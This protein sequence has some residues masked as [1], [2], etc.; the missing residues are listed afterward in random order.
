M[1]ELFNFKTEHDITNSPKEDYPKVWDK[2]AI[3]PPNNLS[4]IKKQ[5]KALKK[6]LHMITAAILN[7]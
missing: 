3:I 7:E 2:I 5:Y 1:V 6:T 4:K